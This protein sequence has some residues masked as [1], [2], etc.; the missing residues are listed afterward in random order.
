MP[1]RWTQQTS[2]LSELT[3]WPHRSMTSGGF[4][5]FIGAT[6]GMLALPLLSMLGTPVVWW[7]LPFFA[8]AVA[9]VWAAL[10]RSDRDRSQTETLRLRPDRI[11]LV[12]MDPNRPERRWT[13]NPHWVTVT[14]HPGPR[15]VPSYL[16]LRGNGREVELGAFL[17]PDE[18]VAL[19][20]ELHAALAE[21]R[22]RA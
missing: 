12:R 22:S 17:T 19:H 11:D 8:A 13:A 4:V 2:E 3:L 21:V 7:L 18:R 16:T 20:G 10:R 5:L 9:A 14:L 15:P 6:V 1:Y